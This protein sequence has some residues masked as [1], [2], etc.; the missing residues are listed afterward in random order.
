MP[1]V[2]RAFALALAVLALAASLLACERTLPPPLITATELAPR[3]AEIG[4]R[5]EVFGVGFPKGKTANLTFRGTLHR[6]GEAPTATDVEAQGTATSAQHVELAMTEALQALFCG[7]GDRAAHTTFRGEVEIAFPAIAPGAPPVAAVVP[8]VTLDL[9]PA[10]PRRAIAEARRADAERA[11]RFLG[12]TLA[13]QPAPEGGLSVRSVTPGSRADEAGILAGDFLSTFDGVRVGALD[14]LVPSGAR[15]RVA[16][17]V[18]RGDGPEIVKDAAIDGFRFAAPRDLALAALVLL[19]AAFVVVLFFAPSAGLLARLERRVAAKIRRGFRLRAAGLAERRSALLA[20]VAASLLFA[21]MPFGRYVVLADVD[22][23]LLFLVAVTSLATIGWLTGGF[24][25]AAQITSFEVPA[26][27]AI[28]C[29]VLMTGS[30]RLHDI[31]HAQGGAPWSW[32]A[33]RSPVAFALFALHFTSAL[34]QGGL[35]PPEL[36]EA[37]AEPR[38]VPRGPF[39]NKVSRF[40]EAANIVVTCGTGAALFL[41]GWQIPGTSLGQQHASLALELA[42]SALFLAKAAALL[43]FAVGLRRVL[44]VA[45][46]EQ[47]MRFCWRW[48]VPIAIS[49]LLLT[50]GWLAW[51]PNA[52]V[53]RLVGLGTC[54]VVALALLRFAQRVRFAARFAEEAPTSPFL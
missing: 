51:S 14:D 54:V 17:G 28:A 22:I 46:V 35:V 20:S 39:A 45:K 50:L 37:D 32:Y 21:V 36:A 40:A 18:R 9:R 3:E 8:N 15:A 12:L 16:I 26:A 52:V 48:L 47:T 43:G 49:A 1:S 19:V 24:R 33:F 27:I 4:D 2:F 29:V 5:L 53:E 42:G 10:A 11:V 13:D 23:G 41:G 34:A 31:V 7:R 44:P 25:S 38:R 6:P 30:T